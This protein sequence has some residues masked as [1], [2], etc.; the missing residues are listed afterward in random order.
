[1]S[2]LGRGL[3]EFQV[4]VFV[5]GTVTAKVLPAVSAYCITTT[6]IIIIHYNTHFGNLSLAAAATS[7]IFV[8]TD[9]CL[10]RQKCGGGR[11]VLCACRTEFTAHSV[12]Q[13]YT[14]IVYFASRVC[15]C[16]HVVCVEFEQY[17]L[18]NNV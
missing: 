9:R 12:S 13:I 4:E 7:S 14:C 10:S 16:V 17:V 8:A 18:V 15:V 2:Y 3:V 5:T 11:S 6:T 1:M